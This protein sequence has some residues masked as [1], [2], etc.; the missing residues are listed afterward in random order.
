MEGRLK[1]EEAKP[2]MKI[3]ADPFEVN[4]S[5]VE[6]CYFGQKLKDRDVSLCPRCNAVFDA[7]VVALSEK[8]RMKKELAHKEE[9]VRQKQEAR[10]TE[11]SNVMAVPSIQMQWVGGS[12]GARFPRYNDF[13]GYQ[14]FRGGNRGRGRDRGFSH[15]YFRGR[16]RFHSR[17]AHYKKSGLWA[18]HSFS[19]V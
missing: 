4:S 15:R 3:D 2:E 6:P 17:N 16:V 7:D 1:F 9:Q 5:F 10:R 8:E 11:S 13:S 19:H 14:N 12:S 18:P